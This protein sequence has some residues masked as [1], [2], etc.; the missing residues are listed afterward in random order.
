[1]SDGAGRASYL[2]R[3]SF[4]VLRYL[5]DHPERVVSKEELFETVWADATD[6]L[7]QCVTEI[8]RALGPTGRDSVAV[9]S[10]VRV[11]QGQ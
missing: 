11:P 8:R 10:K 5:V 1:V 7:A 2:R 9:S 6:S 3:K 4:D